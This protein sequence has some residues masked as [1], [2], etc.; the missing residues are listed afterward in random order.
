MS[1]RSE[2]TKYYYTT[3]FH[4]FILFIWVGGLTSWHFQEIFH[5]YILQKNYIIEN[6]LILKY[7]L[8]TYVVTYIFIT[9]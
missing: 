7:L 9:I 3:S 6:R 1:A 8:N 2:L 4:F 5:L